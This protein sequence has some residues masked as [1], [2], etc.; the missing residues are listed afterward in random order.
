[1]TRSLFRNLFAVMALSGCFW[2]KCLAESD[3]SFALVGVNAITMEDDRVMP[4]QTVVVREG[5]IDRIENA[6]TIVIPEG[7]R[8]IDAHGKYL[9]PGMAE[10]HAHIPI[11][12]DGDVAPAHEAMM[13]FVAHGITTIRGMKGD[14]YHLTLKRQT[15]SG[16]VVGPRIFTCGARLNNGTVKTIEGAH[17]IVKEQSEAGFDFVKIHRNLS[18][19]LFHAI[20][21]AADSHGLGIAGHVPEAVGIREALTRNYVTVD[22]F[23]GYMEGLVSDSVKVVPFRNGGLFA[24]P[25]S[26]DVDLSKLD[27]LIELTRQKGT[28]MV[29]TSAWL[30]RLVTPRDPRIYLAEEGMAYMPKRTRDNWA[31]NKQMRNQRIDPEV[32]QMYVAIRRLLLKRMHDEGVGM[33]FGCDAPQFA[34]VPGFSMKHEVKEYQLSGLSNYEILKMA[35]VNPAIFFEKTDEFGQIRK[36][37][38]ADLVLLDGNPLEDMSY[39]DRPRAVSLKG[40]LLTRDYLDKELGKIKEKYRN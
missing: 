40:R 30:E 5:R 31:R 18:P 19:E 12:V 35:T 4:S 27:G 1:M 17:A 11:P 13:L 38:V 15:A 20:A 21:D 14:R 7:I 36:G 34:N 2:P 8:R 10:L 28:W 6:D 37:Q 26:T 32:A 22:H 9:I 25:L 29:P 24:V 3:H 33:L 39:L 16:E 23:D